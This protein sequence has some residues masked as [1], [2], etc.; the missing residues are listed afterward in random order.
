[1]TGLVGAGLKAP[2][3]LTHNMA[4]G[5]HNLPKMYGDEVRPVEKVTDVQSGL[6]AAGKVSPPLFYFILMITSVSG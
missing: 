1:V 4:R 3:E 6:V 5:F 2:M